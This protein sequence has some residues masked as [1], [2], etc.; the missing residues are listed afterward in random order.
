MQA[1]WGSPLCGQG[2]LRCPSCS[3]RS[4]GP[5]L[6]SGTCGGAPGLGS[7]PQADAGQHK[8]PPA[9]AAATGDMAQE[10]GPPAVNGCVTP[11]PAGVLR[12]RL[13]QD[14]S[15][16]AGDRH[17]SSTQDSGTGGSAPGGP[18]GGGRRAP[19]RVHLLSAEDAYD[20][21]MAVARSGGRC[22]E[23]K[24]RL[25]LK[26]RRQLWGRGAVGGGGT[27]SLKPNKPPNTTPKRARCAMGTQDSAR[28][29]RLRGAGRPARLCCCTPSCPAL[30][31]APPA[32]GPLLDV[33]L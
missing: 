14:E 1:G 4:H 32:R 33:V 26:V 5:P 31:P 6:C 21:V 23:C 20:P 29:S 3:A 28:P 25:K 24:E 30:A 15:S 19:I 27:D 18:L 9:G 2:E 17:G 11:Q 22:R 12:R 10:Q 13:A 7:P 16:P 8:G